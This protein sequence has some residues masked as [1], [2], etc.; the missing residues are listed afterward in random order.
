MKRSVFVLA[1]IA[2]VVVVASAS[3]TNGRAALAGSVPPWASAAALKGT[4]SSS[5]GV[6]FRVYLNLRDQAKA[7]ALA[8]AL[9]DPKSSSHGRF[10]SPGEFQSQFAPA[11]RDVNAVKDWLKSQG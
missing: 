4:P 5:D 1:L 6:G 9:N 8:R 3:G 7:E 10:L 2:A 11:Q